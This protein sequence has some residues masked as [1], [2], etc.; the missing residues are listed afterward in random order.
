MRMTYVVFGQYCWGAGKTMDAALKKAKLARPPILGGGPDMDHNVYKA[1]PDF[2]VD[3]DGKI[4]ARKLV[5]LHEV[6]YVDGVRNV[7]TLS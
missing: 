1:S 6:R 4:S 7:K 5:K 2:V 3:E